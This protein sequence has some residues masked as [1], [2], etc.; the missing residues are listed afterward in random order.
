MH[1]KEAG[2][3][4]RQATISLPLHPSGEPVSFSISL[5]PIPL[6]S[7]TNLA[8]GHV[9]CLWSQFQGLCSYW[10]T[11]LVHGG[12]ECPYTANVYRIFWE[13]LCKTSQP[14]WV[15]ED[16]SGEHLLWI[17]DCI[18]LLLHQV[19]WIPGLQQLRRSGTCQS[20]SGTFHLG[21][22]PSKYV[23]GNANLSTAHMQM[24]LSNLKHGA[25]EYM[26]HLATHLFG[27]QSW[28]SWQQWWGR[29]PDGPREVC[30]QWPGSHRGS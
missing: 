3:D 30:E 23:H 22:N 10:A 27:F 28:V 17:N 25:A 18:K 26:K 19:S 11:A 2:V 9:G 8:H 21:G 6:A 14:S 7:S 4:V 1:H 20:E 5:M 13:N 24:L 16:I 12:G 29:S 15:W